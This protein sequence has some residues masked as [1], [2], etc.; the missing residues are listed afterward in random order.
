MRLT[1]ERLPLGR[2]ARTTSPWRILGYLGAIAAAFLVFRGFQAGEVRPLLLPTP[3]PTRTAASFAEEG[4]TNFSAGRLEEAIRAYQQAAQV[5]PEEASLG[6]ELARIQTYSSALLTTAGERRARL[7]E[8]QNSIE[9]AL[10]TSPD[11][12]FVQAVSALVY[13]WS[14]AVEPIADERERFLKLAETAAIRALQLDPGSTL[15]LA[16]YAELLLDQGKFAQAYDLAEQAAG[17]TDPLAPESMDVHRVFGTVLEG[18]GAYRQAIEEYRAAAEIAPN[19][20]YLYLLIGANFRQLAGNAPNLN[21]RRLLMEQALEAFDRAARINE[22]L[23]I[24]DPTPYL[25]IGRTYLQDGEF[26]IAAINVERALAIDPSNPEVYGRLGI[27][28]FK[29]RNYESAVEVLRC[30]VEGC[31]AA[32]S[33]ELLCGLKVILCDEDA[34]PEEV[35]QIVPGLPLEDGSLE[36]YYTYASVL[37]SFRGS[38]DVPNACGRAESLFQQLLSSYGSDPIVAGIVAENRALCAGGVPT[39]TPIPQVTPPDQMTS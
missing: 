11:D 7:A 27:I 5:A 34:S 32:E 33:G 15:A 31:S 24:Q 3:T 19:F 38:G 8:A 9:R 16:Y 2:S 28:F 26:F 12:P 35:G 25:S 23:G 37:T 13:D 36:F 18:N 4:K 1:G 21:D 14:A 6:A 39:S 30:A 29:A 20:T 17:Q 22:Q 10:E